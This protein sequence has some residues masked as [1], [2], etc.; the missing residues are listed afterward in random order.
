MS[1]NAAVS[2]DLSIENNYL[3]FIQMMFLREHIKDCHIEDHDHYNGCLKVITDSM[4]ATYQ[5]DVPNRNELS[6]SQYVQNTFNNIW[7][8]GKDSFIEQYN[9]W[10][11]FEHNLNI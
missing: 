3:S 6:F 9:N 2:F 1:K 4:Y 11:S 5:K 10:L 8:K 7:H